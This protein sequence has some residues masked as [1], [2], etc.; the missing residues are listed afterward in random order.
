[1]RVK[2]GH[3]RL[4]RAQDVA[5]VVA[6]PGV[7]ELAIL[8]HHGRLHCGGT[9]VQADEHAARVALELAAG[10]D[11]LGVARAELGKVV[12][13]R[14]QR[15]EAG[16]LG[17]LRVAQAI[18]RLDELAQAHEPARLMRHGS[19]GGHEQMRVLGHDD[20]LVV[21]VER[22]VEAVAKLGEV[23]QRAAEERHMAA[24]GATARQARD[25][26]RHHSLEDG[27]GHVLGTGALVQQRLDVGLGEH[28]AA[29]GDGIDVLGALCELV[30]PRGIRVQQGCHLVDERAG[31]AGARAVHA[32][33]DARVEVDDLGVLT[34]ELDGDVGLRDQGL[35]RAL[36]RDDLLHELETEP[37]GEQQAARTRD[38][39]G[40]LR[41]G[42]Q[43][44]RA[45]EQVAR[46]CANIGV[47]TL[48]LGV[49]DCILV[50]QD[51]ELDGGGANV[52][53]QVKRAAR[54]LGVPN[55]VLNGL[56]LHV[57]HQ[58]FLPVEPE[59]MSLKSIAGMSIFSPMSLAP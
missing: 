40:H 2:V 1:M 21:E 49:D 14:K 46:A 52:D 27:G 58:S 50:V 56:G 4:G 38:G 5:V 12:V 47:M 15:L 55:R 42:Q 8:S 13:G 26:L 25:G 23:L 10:H 33:F 28:A 6:V 39:A 53:A 45:L 19:A 32:L 30:Q 24:D 20:V 51:R 37:L 54:I 36:A 29:A 9:G 43:R 34:A 16:D 44:R 41:L 22:E 35:H 59:V 57:G 3:D 31:A 17:A 48:V 11:L 7:E 18:D